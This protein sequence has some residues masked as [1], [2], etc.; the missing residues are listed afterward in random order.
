MLVRRA[1][2]GP[3]RILQSFCQRHIAFAAANDMGMRETRVGEPSGVVDFWLRVVL[4]VPAG[5]AMI[6]GITT[7]GVVVVVVAC[8]AGAHSDR[9][10]A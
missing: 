6:S 10:G 2:Q 3:Q 5:G 9:G 7:T 4:S 8:H 1:A